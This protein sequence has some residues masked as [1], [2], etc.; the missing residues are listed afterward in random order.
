VFATDRADR[1]VREPRMIASGAP[2]QDR[3]RPCVW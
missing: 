3:R 1:L 2:W